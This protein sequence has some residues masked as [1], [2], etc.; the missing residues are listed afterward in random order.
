MPPPQR[1]HREAEPGPP[2]PRRTPGQAEG[3]RNLGD[4]SEESGPSATPGSAE[5]ERETIDTA[6]DEREVR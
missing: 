2:L 3:T 1:R 6:L 4:G 5:G